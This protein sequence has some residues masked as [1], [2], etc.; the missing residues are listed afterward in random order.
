[1]NTPMVSIR[2]RSIGTCWTPRHCV[3]KPC[4]AFHRNGGF[5]GATG[6]DQFSGMP[7]STAVT[8][9]TISEIASIRAGPQS[10][11]RDQRT[12]AV[13]VHA[14]RIDLEAFAQS[15]LAHSSPPP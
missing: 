10:D 1:M 6:V 14:S 2:L 11:G 13:L 4:G 3:H 7:G 5:V 15:G 12:R 8:R 9:L